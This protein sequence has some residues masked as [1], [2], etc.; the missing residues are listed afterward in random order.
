MHWG[1]VSTVCLP[2]CPVWLPLAAG[3]WEQSGQSTLQREAVTKEDSG[4]YTCMAENG[5]GSVKAIAFVYVKGTL[6]GGGGSL[7][8][9]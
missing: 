9:C 8:E 2:N 3:I 7:V 4:T 6:A 5:V 1:A